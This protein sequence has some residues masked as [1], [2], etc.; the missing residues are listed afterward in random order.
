MKRILALAVAGML[1]LGWG[2]GEALAWSRGRYHHHRSRSRVT[3]H[4]GF[5]A[6]LYYP[7]YYYRPYYY[8]PYYYYPAP[9]YYPPAPVYY[10][11]APVYRSGGINEFFG[12]VLGAIGGGVIGHQIGSGSGRAAATVGGVLLGSL[13][14]NRIGFQL[15]DYD[16]RLA[17]RSTQYALE[18]MR[19][20]SAVEWRGA[21]SGAFGTVVPRPAFQNQAG[22][23]CREFQET[24]I[25]GGRQESA[26]GTAC[27][28][29]DGQW[30]IV[31]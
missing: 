9:V 6:P 18:S 30:R 17:Y 13:I 28:Q 16:R 19:S 1:F 5:G 21:E 3:F 26:Y 25:I 7:A 12:T 2:A 14:G 15:D 4:L 8:R 22:Q 29:E 10:E 24:V 11:P 27:R 23:Y 31:Q 20:G